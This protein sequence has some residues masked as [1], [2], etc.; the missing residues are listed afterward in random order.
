VKKAGAAV[1]FYAN[2]AT[3]INTVIEELIRD[4]GF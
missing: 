1:L 3:S 2:D 4:N